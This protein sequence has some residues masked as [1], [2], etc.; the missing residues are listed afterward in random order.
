MKRKIM[1]DLIRWKEKQKRKPL[2][3]QGARQ[4][5]KT[6]I[7]KHF[8]EE[9][10]RNI[11]YINF[12]NNPRMEEVFR[13]DFNIN[14][15]LDAFQIETGAIVDPETLLIFD[16]I[17][18]VPKAI[19]SL[20][21][22]NE[23]RPEIPVVAAG[24]LL[25]IAHHSGISFPVGKV[26]L[27][28][29]Y[30]MSFTEFL[31]A[32]E[33]TDLMSLLEK[34]DFEMI[35]VFRDRYTTLLGQYCF[36][37]GMP[38]AV[39]IFAE[40]GNYQEVRSYQKDLLKLY[41]Q[42]FSKHIVSN[43]AERARMVWRSILSQ[44]AREN[45]KFIYGHLKPGSRSKDYEDAIQW[46]VDCG[47]V[48]KVPRISKP[49]IPLAAYRDISAFKLFIHDVG[50]LTAMGDVD[51]KVLL[52]GDR[53]YREFKGSLTEQYVLIQLVADLGLEPFYYSAE[54]SSG[55]IDFV[56]QHKG[57]VVPIEVKAAENLQGKSLKAFSEK[58]GSG[59]AIRFSLANYREESWMTNMPLYTVACLL[60]IL[61]K[62]KTI[63]P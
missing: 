49:G 23:E 1:Q 16:E 20:K 42:D 6:W 29:M 28:D 19:Q 22:F 8:G 13:G 57:A 58:F 43:T 15:L 62:G 38:E 12:D 21:Y 34:G 63:D 27:L 44:L 30:P 5:G 56:I 52:E 53:I 2:I 54:K 60:K 48:I 7:L 36:I 14:R 55:E 51:I 37:G 33:E 3:I 35:K 11:A 18:E 39:G 17:Q 10:F 47:L 31:Q 50:L 45:R 46:L 40:T 41:E 24:S 61:E 4:V 59:Q 26:E 25:G 9:H 32:M